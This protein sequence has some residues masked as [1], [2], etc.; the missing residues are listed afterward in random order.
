MTRSF[1]PEI[2]DEIAH[3]ETLCAIYSDLQLIYETMRMLGILADNPVRLG[4]VLLVGF[5]RSVTL[6]DRRAVKRLCRLAKSRSLKQHFSAEEWQ[7]LPQEISLLADALTEEEETILRRVAE[8]MVQERFEPRWPSTAK[9]LTAWKA[10]K[11]KAPEDQ[12]ANSGLPSPQVAG[13]VMI[14]TNLAATYGWAIGNRK[15]TEVREVAPQSGRYVVVFPGK[16]R[17]LEFFSREESFLAALQRHVHGTLGK[18]VASKIV[19]GSLYFHQKHVHEGGHPND[20]ITITVK[21]VAQLIGGGA[22]KRNRSIDKNFRSLFGRTFLLLGLARAV[23]VPDRFGS[24][25]SL[26]WIRSPL[27]HIEFEAGR[28]N[29]YDLENP[30]DVIG[31]R[32]G[33]VFQAAVYGG[34]RLARSVAPLDFVTYF[35]WNSRSQA[36]EQCLHLYYTQMFQLHLDKG[37]V[38]KAPIAEIMDE[39][40]LTLMDDK[41]H[42]SRRYDRFL[43]AHDTLQKAGIIGGWDIVDRGVPLEEQIIIVR[44]SK[45]LLDRIRDA[46]ET[47]PLVTTVS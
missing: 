22:I 17:Q 38:I 34:G 23:W 9:A 20:V 35:N 2:P 5:A 42:V 18:P 24:N 8:M 25:A 31:F 30:G 29:P 37:G 7:G 15:P 26:D 40:G 1:T 3:D 27:Y 4:R 41:R 32:L 12:E 46:V 19:V 47:P 6:R 36:D 44:P 21:D 45:E 43:E 13:H 39:A 11:V 14:P 16:N 33:E 10:L 28:G